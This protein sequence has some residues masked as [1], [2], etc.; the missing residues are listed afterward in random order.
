LGFL[1][2]AFPISVFQSARPRPRRGNGHFSPFDTIVH[3]WQR[4]DGMSETQNQFSL[5]R[6]ASI[7]GSA[8]KKQIY[9]ST[10]Q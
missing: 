1:L 3:L 10:N 9:Q 2:S 7:I 5:T 8:A 6:V 4:G